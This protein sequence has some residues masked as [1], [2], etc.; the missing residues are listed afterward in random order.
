MNFFFDTSAFNAAL[1][2]GGILDG[3]VASC[4]QVLGELA[5]TYNVNPRRAEALCNTFAKLSGHRVVRPA[6]EL[7]KDEIISFSHGRK[8]DQIF[9]ERDRFNGVFKPVLD[10][11]CSGVFAKDVEAF[12]GTIK[13]NKD[14]FLHGIKNLIDLNVTEEAHSFKELIDSF[15]ESQLV[16][17]M[18]T[19]MRTWNILASDENIKLLIRNKEKVP[20][21]WLFIVIPHALSYLYRTD[22]KTKPKRGINYDMSIILNSVSFDIFV[23]EDGDARAL[24]NTLFPDRKTICYSQIKTLT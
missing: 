11:L 15:P 22:K 17:E 10:N 14:D 6:P 18:Q 8:F 3:D 5:A 19:M 1:D 2:Q 21:F 4:P 24:Y 16:W 20:H 12:I 7:A 13:K 9:F 23:T